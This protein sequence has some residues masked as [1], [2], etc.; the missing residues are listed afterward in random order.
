M[1]PFRKPKIKKEETVSTE[2]GH[3]W[4]E[5]LNAQ[6]V[7]I[8]PSMFVGELPTHD[9]CCYCELSYDTYAKVRDPAHG[10]FAPQD[11]VP[12]RP[13]GLC[14]ARIARK[15]R[16]DGWVEYSVAKPSPE[17]T[18]EIRKPLWPEGETATSKGSR[19]RREWNVTG[20]MW[21]PAKAAA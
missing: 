15:M 12:P 8:L 16:E 7:H 20:L 17:Q 5:K 21:R 10:S 1:W 6:R 13:D 2:N 9:V 18:V 3:C 14:P 4:H 19:I 11:V